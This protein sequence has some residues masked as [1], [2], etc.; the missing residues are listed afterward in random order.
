MFAK[1]KPNTRNIGQNIIYF[2]QVASTNQFALELMKQD[3]AENGTVVIAEFQSNGRGQQGKSWISEPFEN[4]MFSI[5]I[6][7]V[8]KQR[9]DPFLMNKTITL[10][11]FNYL[12]QYIKGH[13]VKIKWPNDILV[14]RKKICGILVE[15]N[16][17]G[18]VLNYSVV[19]IGLN[20]NQNF[21]SVKG[22]NATS[23]SAFSEYEI[24]REQIFAK[25]LEY[26][27]EQ[28]DRLEDGQ[29][30]SIAE[31]FD[32]AL[33]G[34]ADQTLFDINGEI[35]PATIIGCDGYGRLVIEHQGMEK[36][37]VHGSIKQYI[38]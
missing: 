3:M 15:N 8:T 12:N 5:I 24:D 19:G 7:N 26:I 6:K 38:S 31:E 10:A 11:M 27:E 18:S 35:V 2:N 16:F 30:Q 21:E 29:Y 20:V 9:V 14:N 25:L 23:L 13:S 36:P 34:H 22:I 32:R 17:N 37:F 28:I 1:V 33:L 4:L